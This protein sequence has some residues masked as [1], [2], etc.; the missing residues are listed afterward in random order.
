M[1]RLLH[2][3]F[4]RRMTMQPWMIALWIGSLL[5][6][7]ALAWF[8][9][10]QRRRKRLQARFGPEYN[11]AVIGIG[12][13]RRA[14]A[15]L[16]RRE[17][18]AKEL[19]ARPLHPADQERFLSEWKLCQ[20]QFVDDPAGAVDRAD[21]LLVE[22]MR[23]RG[24]TVDTHDERMM[25]VAAAYPQHAARYR[26]ACGILARRQDHEVSTEDLRAAFL[27]YRTLFEDLL[28]GYDEE[29]KQAS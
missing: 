6:A 26:E 1:A 28:G 3:F 25:D 19:S 29:L 4:I 11:R 18:Q 17:T 20:A 12:S 15:E 8:V 9:F 21:R 2:P 10:D 14:E 7:A 23:T 13:R 5:V 24:Y 22:I 27:H 16:E